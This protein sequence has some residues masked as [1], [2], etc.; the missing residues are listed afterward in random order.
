[1]NAD[2]QARFARAQQRLRITTAL[3]SCCF[4]GRD[5]PADIDR[6]QAVVEAEVK[7]AVEAVHERMRQAL[8]EA[9]WNRDEP[10][11]PIRRRG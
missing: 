7:L 8:I 3:P 9:E 11:D 10:T 1:M 5:T 4:G 6:I 2:Q